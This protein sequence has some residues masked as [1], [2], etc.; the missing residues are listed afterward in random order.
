MPA[1]GSSTDSTLFPDWTNLVDNW[2]DTD[3]EWLRNR[4]NQPF[5]DV[6]TRNSIMTGKAQFGMLSTL[7]S[8]S[9]AGGPDFWDGATWQSIRYPNLGFTSDG[10]SFTLRR[11]GAGTGVQLMSDGSV[12]MVK[13]VVGTGGLGET[14]DQT[15]I[16]MKVGTKTVK[17]ATDAA[18]LTVDSPVTVT[19]TPTAT[20]A[21]SAPSIT[22]PN[23]TSTGTIA[24]SAVTAASVTATGAVTGAAVQGGD[25]LLGSAPPL[26]TI[27]HRSGGSA[28]IGVGSDSTVQIAGTSMSVA[29]PTTFASTVNVNG[30]TNFV[31]RPVFAFTAAG[32]NVQ[33]WVAGI[34]A[35]AGG[36]APT[37]ACPDGTIY[38]SY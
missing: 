12:N 36:G 16:S 7:Q 19:G 4:V 24:A 5:P 22:V 26:G 27:K 8:G 6:A 34:Y 30:Q 38:I 13:A 10:T 3:A 2:R 23:I 21:I 25:V 1:P 32:Q 20:G 31:G 29:P 37:Q 28:Q 15:G 9:V 17:L 11:Q 18:G 33:T 14:L 35:V